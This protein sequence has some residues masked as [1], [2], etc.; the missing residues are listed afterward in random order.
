MVENICKVYMPNV[1][2][3]FLNLPR[4]HKSLR[5]KTNVNRMTGNLTAIF[6]HV[7]TVGMEAIHDWS[8]KTNMPHLL[9]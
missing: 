5:K 9:K 8:T 3:C 4:L 7:K 2:A 6:D 1:R